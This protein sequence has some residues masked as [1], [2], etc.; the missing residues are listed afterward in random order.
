MR[1]LLQARVSTRKISS[2]IWWNFGEKL[3]KIVLFNAEAFSNVATYV[4]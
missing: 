3:E 2:C 1:L 4:M